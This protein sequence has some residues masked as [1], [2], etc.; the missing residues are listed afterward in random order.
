VWPSFGQALFVR[1]SSAPKEQRTAKEHKAKPLL[2]VKTT[3]VMPYRHRLV[4]TQRWTVAR[5]PNR[6]VL[7]HMC[8]RSCVDSCLD[9]SSGRLVKYLPIQALFPRAPAWRAGA[10]N[11]PLFRSQKT[12]GSGAALPSGCRAAAL[13]A[14]HVPLERPPVR[15]Q[16]MPGVQPHDHRAAAPWLSPPPK[17][18][19]N[20]QLRAE[21]AEADMWQLTKK[22]NGCR[23][24]TWPATAQPGA[25][26]HLNCPVKMT[27]SAKAWQSVAASRRSP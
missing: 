14:Q 11:P 9:R 8:Y 16:G 1:I 19:V 4:D 24:P 6:L 15:P 23:L 18:P 21:N 5:L 27:T 26:D 22:V 17:T 2:R 20:S 12:E 3:E 10:A 13:R 7:G 25:V